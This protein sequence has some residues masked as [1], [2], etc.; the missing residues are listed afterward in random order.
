MPGGF[1]GIRLL[2][3]K[4][5]HAP[6][7]GSLPHILEGVVHLVQGQALRYQLVQLQA[8]LEV[9]LHVAGHIGAEV[10]AAHAAALDAPLPEER[11]AVQFDAR[12]LRDHS[13]DGCRSAGA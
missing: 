2:S 10:V 13:D 1:V 4:H 3:L 7:H 12:S 9:E 11:W 6:R 8:A 5:H